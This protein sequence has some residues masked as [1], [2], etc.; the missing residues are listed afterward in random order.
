M[1]DRLLNIHAVVRKELRTLTRSPLLYVL[2]GVFLG[3]AGYFFY[4]D[5]LYFDLLN[6]D[7]IGLTQG[8]W[9]RFFEDLRLCLL[10]VT[11]VLAARLFAEERRLGTMEMLLTYPLTEVEIVAGKFI[12]LLLVF[13]PLLAVTVLYPASLAL[14]WPVDPW[15][16]VATY[17]GAALLGLACLSCGMF[18]SAFATQQS[19][20]AL[21]AFG[22]LFFSW[23]L[24]WN[25]AAA[26]PTLLAILRRLSLFDR[27]Y[28]FTR[29]TI[30][31][32]DV[33]Y[34]MI[35]ST[36]FVWWSCEALRWRWQR[37]GKAQVLRVILLLLVG[38]GTD[39][40]AM[41]HNHS[42][43][44]VREKESL[45]SSE[46]V[47]ALGGVQTPV[48]LLLFYEPGRYRET[49]YLAEKCSRAS[50]M[51]NV[52]L[53]DL[54]REPA[55][56]REY[57]V[58]TYGTVV[59]EANGRRE[60]VYPAEER[61]LLNAVASVTDLRPRLVC[62]ST[63]H[64][65][66]EAATTQEVADEEPKG[67]GDLLERL[68]YRWQEVELA[69]E[70]T[71]PDTCLLL[72]V[73]GPRQDF[74]GEEVNAVINFLSNGG[75]ALFLLDH[76]I[77]PTLEAALAPLHVSLGSEILAEGT[78]QLYMRDRQTLPVVD[79]A[80]AKHEPEQFVAVFH[81]AR[82]VNYSASPGIVGGVFL[83]YRSST[84]GVVPVGVA[85]EI[86]GA[87]P[88]RFMVVG[89]ADFLAGRLFLRE[90]NRALLLR[91]L[92]WL[93]GRSA[94][95]SPSG[96]RYA[97]APLSV[98]QTRLLFGIAMTPPLLFLVA[99]G[100]AWQRRKMGRRVRDFSLAPWGRGLG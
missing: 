75:N 85:G 42:W 28:D 100:I 64:G 87:Q 30:Q 31:S 18:C 35:V 24:A 8:L 76:T 72:F 23:F 50:S 74:T 95:V 4:T 33:A 40:W 84:H 16:L 19:S 94:D 5:V 98:R 91:M 46:T 47:Q 39:D 26:G 58:R 89:D 86:A 13:L 57:G 88:G 71:V 68:G 55:L 90:S 63:G 66:Y 15:P 34:F 45:L 99:G 67:V 80:L 51:I 53:V 25:E 49:A 1:A 60:L 65:E 96:E 36:L 83:G 79:V 77:L 62:F 82:Q 21:A 41:R 61:L 38:V 52:Q 44:L 59:V 3:L 37:P 97:Y 73:H 54:D 11:P 32:R 20:A 70:M 29:G 7:K 78:A 93:N 69:Q 27:F 81:G 17:A 12:S 43:E 2:G 10:V 6:Q 92:Q 48:R 22:V 14:M 56:A 9:Q